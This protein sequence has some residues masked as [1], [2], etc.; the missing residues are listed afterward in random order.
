MA[1][2][3]NIAV[4]RRRLWTRF[5][6]NNLPKSIEIFLDGK[7]NRLKSQLLSSIL[8]TFHRIWKQKRDWGNQI[9]GRN[10]KKNIF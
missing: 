3:E 2:Y 1:S 10:V 7:E 8:K 4:L 5:E 6:D 9:Q